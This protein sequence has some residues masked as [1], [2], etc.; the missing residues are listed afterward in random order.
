[1]EREQTI[2]FIKLMKRLSEGQQVGLLEI[3]M[4]M[5]RIQAEQKSGGKA[6]ANRRFL[7]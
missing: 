4:G 2:E 6:A 1:M 7:Q 5:A 3:L